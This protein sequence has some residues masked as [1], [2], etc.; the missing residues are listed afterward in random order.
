MAAEEEG[1]ALRVRAGAGR[2]RLGGA[3]AQ[4]RDARDPD[5]GAEVGARRGWSGRA[6][7]GDPAPALEFWSSPG[8]EA[9]K[10]S[11]EKLGGGCRD[12]RSP[13]PPP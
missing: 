12:A 5:G 8:R 11:R 7:A 9:V 3:S 4:A 2:G 13:A 1:G 6:G 10:R